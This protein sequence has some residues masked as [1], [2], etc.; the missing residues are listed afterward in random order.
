M[1]AADSFE[2]KDCSLSFD[3]GKAVLSC[4]E[5]SDGRLMWI[6]RLDDISSVDLVSED[7]SRFFLAC[8]MESVS[9]KFIAL[10]RE[11]GST[12]WI[13]QGLAFL[14]I[15]HH[16]FLYLIFI[17][18]ME[19]FYLLKADPADG[20]IFWHR[21]VSPDLC[22]YSIGSEK[23]VLTYDSGKTEYIDSIEGRLIS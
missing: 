21:R 3:C 6:K 22:E 1:A 18:E 11:D 4:R 12:S 5:S 10:N 16:G 7:D 9:G 8:R 17:D 14:N 20:G 2:M 19:R 15:F 13:I 23:I